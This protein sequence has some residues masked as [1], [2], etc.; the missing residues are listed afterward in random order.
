MIA[1]SKN[2]RTTLNNGSPYETISC[3]KVV[4]SYTKWYGSQDDILTVLSV[5]YATNTLSFCLVSFDSYSDI[6][7]G[8]LFKKK[9][10]VPIDMCWF[11]YSLL[12]TGIGE[13]LRSHT[14]CLI[15]PQSCACLESEAS[16]LC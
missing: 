4:V 11:L 9:T 8:L 15:P 6:G 16:D 7:L 13:V 2:D 12:A 14:T 1:T 3:Y 5:V 10:D